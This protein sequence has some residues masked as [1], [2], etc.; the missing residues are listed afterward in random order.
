MPRK[1]LISLLAE[2]IEK[3]KD[4]KLDFEGLSVA[5]QLIRREKKVNVLNVPVCAYQYDQEGKDAWMIVCNWEYSELGDRSFAVPGA[6]E[7]V[8]PDRI[9][10]QGTLSHIAMWCVLPKEGMILAFTTCD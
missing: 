7:P 10:V 1:G 3:A 5:L 4:E 8:D 6:N 9:A 2:L